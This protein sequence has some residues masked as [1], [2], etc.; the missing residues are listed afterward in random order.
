MDRVDMWNVLICKTRGCL[1]FDFFSL[2][3]G[4]ALRNQ[5]KCR[6]YNQ[7][8]TIQPNTEALW[9]TQNTTEMLQQFNSLL[10]LMEIS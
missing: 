2:M 3:N 1:I 8:N 4:A 5:T 9:V 10:H 6:Q 7:Y